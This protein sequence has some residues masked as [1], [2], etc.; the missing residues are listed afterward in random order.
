MEEEY[1]QL[2]K[3]AKFASLNAYAPYSGFAV[4][5]AVLCANGKIYSGCNVENVSYAATV[6]AERTA[7]VKAVSE[8]ANK[9]KALAVY[10]DTEETIFPC[11]ICRQFLVEF[12]AD[13][14]KIFACNKKDEYEEYS[15]SDLLPHAFDSY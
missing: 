5:A 1:R 13:D 11:G 7:A 2:I 12:A 6:C 4:G 9:F 3:E 8:G 14:M 10:A 15:L